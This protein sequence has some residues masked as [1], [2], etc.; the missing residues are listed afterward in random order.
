MVKLFFKSLLLF[1]IIMASILFIIG[2]GFMWFKIYS[3]WIPSLP[4][5]VIL[6]VFTTCLLLISFGIV[7]S[8]E[9]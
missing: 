4:G 3:I 5:S 2:F 9:A 7:L 1:S 8:I 6:S